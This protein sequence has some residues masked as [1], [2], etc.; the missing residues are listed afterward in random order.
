L[1]RFRPAARPVIDDFDVEVAAAHGD[2]G[3]GIM[4]SCAGELDELVRRN[5]QTL[6][7]TT[8]R[9]AK[10]RRGCGSVAGSANGG[11]AEDRAGKVCRYGESPHADAR[12]GWIRGSIDAGAVIDGENDGRRF[13]VQDGTTCRK[14]QPQSWRR[15]AAA[16]R[17]WPGRA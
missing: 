12:R 2:C 13:I 14:G 4:G 7:S 17:A 16:A 3:G 5:L 15:V 1:A 9:T 6:P 11:S 8:I 10:P